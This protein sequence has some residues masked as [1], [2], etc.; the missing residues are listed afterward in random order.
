MAVGLRESLC[1]EFL[2]MAGLVS[3]VLLGSS[4]PRHDDFRPFLR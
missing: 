3:L 4:S 2:M 1:L